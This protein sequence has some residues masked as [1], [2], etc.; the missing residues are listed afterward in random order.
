M[1]KRVLEKYGSSFNGVSSYV[2]FGNS[3]TL[4]GFASGITVGLALRFKGWAADVMILGIFGGA[5]N[6]AYMV[7]EDTP[8]FVGWVTFRTWYTDGTTS[9]YGFIRKN[10]VYDGKLHFIA[11]SVDALAGTISTYVDLADVSADYPNNAWGDPLGIGASN[12]NLV[13]GAEPTLVGFSTIEV[14]KLFILNRPSTAS[15]LRDEMLGVER[16]VGVALRCRFNEGRGAIL[17]DYSGNNNHGT[18]VGA[19][20]VK[21]P[22]KVIRFG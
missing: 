1:G 15:Q 6:R 10:R 7:V 11:L 21:A 4:S 5:G 22:R 2:N 18:I 12:S 17:H 20:W 9:R 16:N 13:L 19:K 14:Y 8:G 3:P